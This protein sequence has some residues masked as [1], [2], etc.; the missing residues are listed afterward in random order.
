MK[1]G[2]VVIFVVLGILL[3]Q[4][5]AQ[6][7]NLNMPMTVKEAKAMALAVLPS[8]TKKLPGFSLELD[9]SEKQGVPKYYVFMAVWA[10]APGGSAVIGFYAVD[11]GTG[12]VWD[13]NVWST[14]ALSTPLLRQLQSRF[15]R[16]I[17][18]TA[19]GYQRIRRGCPLCE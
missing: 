4:R 14:D 13:A 3:M 10:G 1:K 11:P 7:D 12:D 9:D 19:A 18:L 15:R 17:G 5:V 2:P 6:A 16:H 8:K